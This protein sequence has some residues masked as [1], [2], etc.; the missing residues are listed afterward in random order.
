[1]RY[2]GYTNDFQ[3]NVDNTTL[4]V[5]GGV[6]NNQKAIASFFDDVI[7][8]HTPFPVIVKNGN[9]VQLNQNAARENTLLNATIA[10]D[11]YMYGRVLT[12]ADFSATPTSKPPKWTVSYTTLVESSAI[13]LSAAPSNGQ[14]QSLLG[15]VTTTI[16]AQGTPGGLTIH[17][18]TADASGLFQ[19]TTNLVPNGRNT[20]TWRWPAKAAA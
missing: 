13:N 20:T 10:L 14:I 5:G 6:D 16:A 18:W 17:A 4:Y 8:T 9:I 7:L 3:N 19:T 11:N 2:N 15:P 12:A 1:M